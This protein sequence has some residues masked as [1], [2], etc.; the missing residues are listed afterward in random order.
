MSMQR[1]H[2]ES[3]KSYYMES[4]KAEGPFAE[5]SDAAGA[6]DDS[7]E[8]VLSKEKKFAT[9]LEIVKNLIEDQGSFVYDLLSEMPD[10]EIDCI[11]KNVASLFINSIEGLHEIV[12]ERDSRN[13]AAGSVEDLLPPV[14]PVRL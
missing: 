9:K 13:G 1:G 14:V 8:W 5:G 3:V 2:L 10:H 4:V 12:A 11:M 7:G 6:L